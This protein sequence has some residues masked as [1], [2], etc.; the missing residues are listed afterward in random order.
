M[1]AE[2]NKLF[3]A[4][5]EFLKEFRNYI[6][7]LL[8]KEFGQKWSQQYR[9]SLSK[10]Q[11]KLW[12]EMSNDGVF[13]LDLIDF[14][15]LSSFAIMYKNLLEPYLGK[16]IAKHLPTWLDEMRLSRNHIFHL[17][18]DPLKETSIIKTWIYMREI[19]EILKMEVLNQKLKEL[20]QGQDL[21]S[22]VTK[23]FE[24]N[25]SEK[26]NAFIEII[27]SSEEV[28]PQIEEIKTEGTNILHIEGKSNEFKHL[29]FNSFIKELKRGNQTGL[30]LT[31][32]V[33]SDFYMID[34]LCKWISIKNNCI[35]IDKSSSKIVFNFEK[36]TIS[37]LFFLK[38][39]RSIN[40]KKAI[41]TYLK[42]YE[43]YDSRYR[44]PF[45]RSRDRHILDF[46]FNYLNFTKFGMSFSIWDGVKKY[47]TFDCD[48]YYDLTNEQLRNFYLFYAYLAAYVFEKDIN[49][50]IRTDSLHSVTI[51]KRIYFHLDM[52]DIQ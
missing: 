26:N 20:Q 32:N 3:F 52:D 39:R 34:N 1:T 13:L 19:A 50:L 2:E 10:N 23:G 33:R 24:T 36:K 15:N 16:K 41:K 8:T 11:K 37:E 51:L 45:S 22:T 49:E 31:N 18:S 6:V 46:S 30:K 28:N 48:I 29:N 5:S 40:Y 44:S 12:D 25:Q 17:R 14:G 43:G 35:V 9:N 47:K 4:L 42:T 38:P 7:D 27:N 21:H